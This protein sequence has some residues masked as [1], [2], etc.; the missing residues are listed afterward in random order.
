[1]ELK[2]KCVLS[3]SEQIKEKFKIA[4]ETVKM[5]TKFL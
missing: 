5:D 4:M 1:M 3:T 2:Q